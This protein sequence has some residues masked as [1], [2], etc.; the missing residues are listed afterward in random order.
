MAILEGHRRELEI[1]GGPKRQ[2]GKHSVPLAGL[3][4]LSQ[5]ARRLALSLL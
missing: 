1:I 4:T 3:V 5:V 2:E